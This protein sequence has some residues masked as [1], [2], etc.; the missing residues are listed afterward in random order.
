MRWGFLNLAL[1]NFKHAIEIFENLIIPKADH[2]IAAFC[3]S[4]RTHSIRSGLFDMLA[5]IQLDDQLSRRTGKVGDVIS[6]GVLTTESHRNNAFPKSIPEH[7][8]DIRAVTT[9]VS[10]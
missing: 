9:K 10:R 2:T 5:S 8:F 3:Q 4:S 6:K 7:P 1:D